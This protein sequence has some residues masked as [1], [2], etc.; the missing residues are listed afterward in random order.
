M[1]IN[2]SCIMAETRLGGVA[3]GTISVYILPKS[4]QVNFFMEYNDV[5]MVTELTYPKI[6]PSTRVVP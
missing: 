6:R 1:Q 4:G 5:R 2:Q 3:V